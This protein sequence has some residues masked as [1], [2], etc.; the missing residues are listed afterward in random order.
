MHKS[1]YSVLILLYSK[2]LL[3][4]SLDLADDADTSTRFS[5]IVEKLDQFALNWP[6]AKNQ[7]IFMLDHPFNFTGN[8]LMIYLHIQKTGG[9]TF[10][11]A[12]VDRLRSRSDRHKKLCIKEKGISKRR[13]SR[14]LVDDKVASLTT[15]Q[16]HGIEAI[17]K[18]GNSKPNAGTPSVEPTTP[19]S[20]S[21]RPRSQFDS[22]FN[23][24][25]VW[26]YSR[27]SV[28]WR[29]G[30]HADYTEL[31]HCLPRDLTKMVGRQKASQLNP[32]WLVTLR[33]PRARFISEWQHT[34]RQG[35]SWTDSTLTC[36]GFEYGPRYFSKTCAM[37]FRKK[38]SFY[39]FA[40]CPFNLASNRQVRMLAELHLKRSKVDDCYSNIF[41]INL[42][43]DNY[44]YRK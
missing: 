31:K 16:R 36:R 29:C 40:N 9:T 34:S 8:D 24:K 2:I 25:D 17:L 37:G 6:S 43:D 33:D 21:A 44:H 32:Y 27:Y 1:I 38:L 19:V 11:R 12:L 10:G 42:N 26:I 7:Q 23:E 14:F 4:D 5:D 28:G 30:L 35:A 41:P 3:I 15:L 39:E 22:K 20:P 13:C 18:E